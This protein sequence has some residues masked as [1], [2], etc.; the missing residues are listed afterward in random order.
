MSGCLFNL[1]GFAILDSSLAPGKSTTARFT[2]QPFSE[3]PLRAYQFVLVGV[4]DPAQAA[5]GK[6]T[7]GANGNFRGPE[8][9]DPVAGFAEILDSNGGCTGFGLDFSS[10]VGSFTW[11]GYVTPF[12]VNNKGDVNKRAT[13]DV[14]LKAKPGAASGQN[15]AVMAITGLWDDSNDNGTVEDSDVLLCTG[16]ATTSLYVT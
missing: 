16:N 3:E 15:S 8:T 6:A 14:V 1:T 10:V 4:D 5:T 12:Q 2:V 9:M 7:W 11:R 13:V